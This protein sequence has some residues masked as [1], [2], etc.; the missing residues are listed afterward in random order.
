MVRRSARVVLAGAADSAILEQ[1]VLVAR[2][3][4]QRRMP[5]AYLDERADGELYLSFLG[6]HHDTLPPLLLIAHQGQIRHVGH[7]LEA[8]SR[9]GSLDWF[10]LCTT[11][12]S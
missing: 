7:G 2:T 4:L 3:P 5:L 8:Q 9:P 11:A 12:A 6:L 10:L 1:G